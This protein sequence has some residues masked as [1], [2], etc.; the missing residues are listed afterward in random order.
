MNVD[1]KMRW[2]ARIFCIAI[3][4]VI[5]KQLLNGSYHY[6]SMEHEYTVTAQSSSLMYYL[7][8]AWYI[9]LFPVCFYFGFIAKSIDA[10]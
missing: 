2:V 6:Y 9:L 5:V 8:L 7:S 1:K 10:E 4:I 3:G